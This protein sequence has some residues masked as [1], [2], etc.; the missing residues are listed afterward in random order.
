MS[1]EESEELEKIDLKP[2][3]AS[4]ATE[5]STQIRDGNSL[6]IPQ[7]LPNLSPSNSI[8]YQIIDHHDIDTYVY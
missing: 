1:D 7:P 3:N 6:F 8:D 5:W 4:T 2:M